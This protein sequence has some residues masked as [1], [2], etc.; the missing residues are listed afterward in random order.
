MNINNLSLGEIA[1]IE[2]YSGHSLADFNDDD[3]NVD[4]RTMC[5][6]GYVIA[7][8]LGLQVEITDIEQLGLDE[9]TQLI[10]QEL[11]TWTNRGE[12]VQKIAEYLEAHPV[13]VE[14]A[15]E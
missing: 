15:G 13:D 6:L 1:A 8:R 9:L 10:N 14:A 2:K 3:T 4:T 7:K 12:K 5:A 11:P